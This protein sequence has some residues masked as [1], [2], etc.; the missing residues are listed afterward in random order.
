MQFQFDAR[1]IAPSQAPEVWPGGWYQLVITGHDIKATQT[2]TGKR[3]VFNVVGNDDTNGKRGQPN[4]IGLN[5]DNPSATAVQMS[6]ETLSAICWVIGKPAINALEELHGIPFYAMAINEKDAQSNNWRAFRNM[7]GVEAI[8]LAQQGGGTTQRSNQPAQGQQQ[9]QPM[10]QQPPQG[11]G[12]WQPPGGAPAGQPAQGG[13][14]PPGQQPQGQ[15]PA[16]QPSGQPPGGGWGPPQGQPQQ[17]TQQPQGQAG[18][19]PPQG[20][21]PMQQQPQQQPSQ[22]WQP[23]SQTPGSQAPWQQR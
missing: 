13:W 5:I 2:G 3:L 6:Y 16:G 23:G 19:G 4:T 18:W 1:R 15:P 14:Q 21:Q 9:Q 10:Q 17:Q 7:Q 11:G 20:Q 22:Q 8:Q 12:G